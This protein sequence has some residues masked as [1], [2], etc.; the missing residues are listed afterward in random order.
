VGHRAIIDVVVKLLTQSGIE[1]H[2]FGCPDSS[3][4]TVPT[5]LSWGGVVGKGRDTSVDL[6][7]C[8]LL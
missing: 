3:L 5:E 6:S 8:R 1:L 2:F 7:M 4:F